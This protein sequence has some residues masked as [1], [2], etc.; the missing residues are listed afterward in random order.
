MQTSRTGL[1]KWLLYARV[2][3]HV[4]YRYRANLSVKFVRRAALLLLAFRHDKPVRNDRAWKLHLYL[5]AYPTPAFFKA[6]ENKLLCSP[7][8]PVS[9]VI[10]TTKACAFACPHCYQRL[11]AGK[12]VSTDVL[13][14]TVEALSATGVAFL[15]VEGGDAFLDF[16]RL[17]DLA[18]HADDSME[19]WVN[20]TGANVTLE[21]LA[22]LKARGVYG[23]MVSMHGS[24]PEAHDAFTGRHGAFYLARQTLAWCDELGLGSAVNC[25]L[26]A[27]D[28]AAGTLPQIMDMA[29]ELRCGFVQLIHPKRA[30]KWLDNA[31]LD[32]QESRLIEDAMHAHRY[33][34]GWRRASYPALA[35][36][37]KEESSGL[38][39]CTAGGV[40]RFYIGASGE[41][42]PC[43]FLNLSFGNVNDESFPTIFARMRTAFPVPCT[44]WLCHTLAVEIADYMRD[45]NITTTPLS[46]S[47]T[48]EI[49][50][51]MKRGGPTGLYKRM[52]IYGQ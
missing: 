48:L 30:G 41:V 2:A 28:M 15:N 7:P 39:G 5:P 37:A 42:Q 38:F 11:D 33:Y 51:R 6:V 25:V 44:D 13:C 31:R 35:A 18:E 9:V 21:K 3:I 12:D 43:E 22:G 47:A 50:S 20:T 17:C 27:E 49:V 34:N 32:E 1:F 24:T 26:T 40:D 19:M 14:K 29:R 52:G 46:T 4:L 10:S 36:Q 16:C 8:R 45:H 23:L